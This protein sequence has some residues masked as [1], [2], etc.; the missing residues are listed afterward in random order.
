MPFIFQITYRARD[1]ERTD[2][3][4][5][6]DH[7]KGGFSKAKEQNTDKLRQYGKGKQEKGKEQE[8]Y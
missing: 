1:R 3:P 7:P 6:P 8:E 5:N 2:H 4:E